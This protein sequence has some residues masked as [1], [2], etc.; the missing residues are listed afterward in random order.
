MLLPVSI[1]PA[2]ELIQRRASSDEDENE[3]EHDMITCSSDAQPQQRKSIGDLMVA[4]LFLQFSVCCC[5][6]DSLFVSLRSGLVWVC[7]CAGVNVITGVGP[8]IFT[9]TSP[10]GGG[11]RNVG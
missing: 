5:G 2:G 4:L 8:P 7:G 10:S 11:S 3:N 9:I 6:L 1:A